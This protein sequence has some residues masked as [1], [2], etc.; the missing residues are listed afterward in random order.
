MTLTSE[1]SNKHFNSSVSPTCW[2]ARAVSGPHPSLGSPP[3][4]QDPHRA[5]PGPRQCSTAASSAG[6]AGGWAA[7][8]APPTPSAD[9]S[10]DAP[11]T[12]ASAALHSSCS[13]H[14]SKHFSGQT[15]RLTNRPLYFNEGPHLMPKSLASTVLCNQRKLHKTAKTMTYVLMGIRK[16]AF[17][18]CCILSALIINL[19]HVTVLNS[20]WQSPE[21][22][23]QLLQT[24]LPAGHIPAVLREGDP[25]SAAPQS[26]FCNPGCRKENLTVTTCCRKG[27]SFCEEV[28]TSQPMWWEPAAL[29]APRCCLLWTG[30]SPESA[31]VWILRLFPQSKMLVETDTVTLCFVCTFVFTGFLFSTMQVSILFLETRG[32]K[33]GSC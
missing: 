26:P 4:C 21:E 7:P 16:S 11:E 19:R 18:V 20:H 9:L 5:E 24:S 10:P 31:N 15:I 17:L 30:A 12:E 29:P 14:H 22:T 3:W 2:A 28:F 8:A 6:C 23:R 32:T 27:A 33:P 13:K 25:Q 1:M